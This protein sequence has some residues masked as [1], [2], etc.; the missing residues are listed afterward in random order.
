MDRGDWLTEKAGGGQG[1]KAVSD[2]KGTLMKECLGR[3]VILLIQVRVIGIERP[4]GTTEAET[5][6]ILHQVLCVRRLP[7]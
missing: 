3:Q 2:L 5:N 6:T 4:V 1:K 7:V